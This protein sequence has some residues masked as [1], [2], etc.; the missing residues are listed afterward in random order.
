MQESAYIRRR[1]AFT[2]L[3][4]F[5]FVLVLHFALGFLNLSFFNRMTCISVIFTW[6]VANDNIVSWLRV[7]QFLKSTFIFQ[8]LVAR[9]N[10]FFFK[11]LVVTS[12]H[13]WCSSRRR[14]IS[15]SHL[16][17]R[18]STSRYFFLFTIRFYPTFDS[19]KEWVNCI[20]HA[21]LPVQVV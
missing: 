13:R 14:N 4:I 21:S 9:L 3:R 5:C 15:T 16:L 7:L 17:S 12:S 2:S 10:L 6:S 18:S 1:N 8:I 11:S 19:S 20:N